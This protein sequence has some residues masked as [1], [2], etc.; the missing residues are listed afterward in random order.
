MASVTNLH[1]DTPPDG[2]G[3]YLG[4]APESRRRSALGMLLTGRPR[5]DDAAVDHFLHFAEEQG[6]D[7]SALWLAGEGGSAGRGKKTPRWTI[8][9]S[10]LRSRGWT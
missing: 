8:S 3:L 6:L 2:G 5:E 1:P 9:S 10:S 7:L 4:P